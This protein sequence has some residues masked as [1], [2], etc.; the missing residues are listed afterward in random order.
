MDDNNDRMC[1]ANSNGRAD[2]YTNPYADTNP[3]THT[4]PYTDTAANDDAIS[5]AHTYTDE[6]ATGNEHATTGKHSPAHRG[7]ITNQNAY[8]SRSM[9]KK[10][11]DGYRL[12]VGIGVYDRI[13]DYPGVQK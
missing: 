8:Y 3:N 9:R 11:C 2:L 6:S 12:S 4:N 7:S 5:D 10:L 13:C 1:R